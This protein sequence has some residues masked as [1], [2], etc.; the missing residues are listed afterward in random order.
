MMSSEWAELKNNG[1]NPINLLNYRFSEGINA[2]IRP[3]LP[4]GPTVQSFDAAGTAYAR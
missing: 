4:G 3:I 2:R 1:L